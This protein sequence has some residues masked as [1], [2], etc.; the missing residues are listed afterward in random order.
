M[1][2]PLFA[3][4]QALFTQMNVQLSRLSASQYARPLEV[5]SGSSVGMHIRHILEFYRCLEEQLPSGTVCYDRR[6]RD[7]ELEHSPQAA[8]TELLRLEKVIFAL[9]Q[10]PLQLQMRYDEETETLETTTQ[11]ELFYTFEHAIHHLALVKI[12]LRACFPEVELVPNLG[13]APATQ[14]YLAG[15]EKEK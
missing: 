13:V 9:P 14:R 8:Q 3:A 6:R 2:E 4:T 11:R 7:P 15:K 5:L 12:G 10:Q 1:K